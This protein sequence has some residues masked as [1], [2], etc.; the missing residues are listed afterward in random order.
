M[1]GQI[2]GVYKEET[3]HFLRCIQEGITPAVT[4]R[5]ALLAVTVV[6]ALERSFA[7]G[8]D[9]KGVAITS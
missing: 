9:E 1:H 3:V 7:S 6:E 8:W 4:G 5:D 2:A